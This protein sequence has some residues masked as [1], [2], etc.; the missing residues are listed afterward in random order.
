MPLN[1]N[2]NQALTQALANGQLH[3]AILLTGDDSNQ[4]AKALDFAK[5]V[6]CHHK[7]HQ[8]PCETCQ[9]C[10][11]FSEFSQIESEHVRYHHPDCLILGG[12]TS[13]TLGI[14]DIRETTTFLSLTPHFGQHKLVLIN[15]VERVTLS[16]QNAL[17]KILEEP[18]TYAQ[19]LLLANQIARLRPTVLSRCVQY[20]LTPPTMNEA[21]KQY[22]AAYG[23][24]SSVPQDILRAL[25][26]L[27]NGHVDKAKQWLESAV[28]AQRDWLVHY[29]VLAKSEKNVQMH[30]VL[31]QNPLEALYFL[32]MAVGDV[33]RY[34]NG[35]QPGDLYILR[36]QEL[37]DLPRKHI[38]KPYCRYLQK[39]QTAIQACQQ[40]AG[41]NKLLL[42]QDLRVFLSDA[43]REIP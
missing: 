31:N 18:P 33:I 27:A 35:L 21:I 43:I 8:Q 20:H 23:T 42:F 36:P 1:N 6:L 10:T 22:Q 11:L 7:T 28:W 17:L 26:Y 25:I 29:F 13:A 41:I 30:Q 4:L 19:F 12:D 40:I 2:I 16:A 14:D 34:A 15:Q 9:S 37:N 39:I 3:H 32:Y 38:N 24:A 5:Y